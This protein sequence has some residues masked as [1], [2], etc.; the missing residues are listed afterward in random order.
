MNFLQAY[1]NILA[2]TMAPDVAK[3]AAY[4][5]GRNYSGAQGRVMEKT[6]AKDKDMQKLL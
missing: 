4:Y 1:F 5:L 2:A 3:K 6:I